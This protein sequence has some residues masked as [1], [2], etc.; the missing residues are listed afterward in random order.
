MTQ[1]FQIP[2]RP[3]L[4]NRPVQQIFINGSWCDA[5]DGRDF[6]TVDPSS[7]APL[8]RIA[9]GGSE[10][11][12]RAV[13]SARAALEGEWARMTPADRQRILLRLADLVEAN[14]DD[15]AMIDTLEMGA[16]IARLPVMRR[17]SPSVI[18]FYA[19]LVTAIEGRTISNSI[20]GDV[21]SYTLREPVGV[22]GAIIPWNAPFPA[23]LIKLCPV[24]AA[25]CTLVLKPS[26]DASL[27]SIRLME[28]LQ[29]AG[30]PPG[31]VNMVTGYG[32]E[33]GAALAAHPGVDK[34]AFTGSTATGR[35]IIAASMGN[36][37]RLSLELGGKSPDIVFADA[38]LDRA[39]AGAAMGV[40]G[41]TGQVC[42]SGSRIFVQRP[43]FDEV[44]TRMADFA[45][46][47]QVGP[48]TDPATQIG[49]IAS[50][51]QLMRVM[52]YLDA[53]KTAG[54]TAVVGGQRLAGALET[55]CFVAPTIFSNVSSDMT[56]VREEIFGPVA[57]VIPFDTEADAV[58]MA[59]DTEYGLGA[60]VWTRDL[61]CAHRM[62]RRIRAGTVW[63]NSYQLMDPAVPMGGMKQSGHGRECG[64]EH[65][66]AFLETK[67]V[68][69]DAG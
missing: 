62:S 25:G 24:L 57:V 66:D 47:L 55:G 5:A 39:V 17:R 67:S 52:S 64:V 60:G 41:N 51:R 23:A 33:A 50:E 3:A 38:D 11:I 15:L 9:R 8:A 1:H 27:S 31:V 45:R 59:N 53:G 13:S 7:G 46:A 16:P 2:P 34:I 58:K 63:V 26:E 12:D 21:V 20:P 6:P 49:P 32:L 40:F 19:G 29:E 65:L 56:I 18:R 37:K 68:W 28:L 48:A 4:L 14:I 35:Q 42:S 22:V 36:L 69:I 61:G 10:D 30:L 54:A 43:V 44:V